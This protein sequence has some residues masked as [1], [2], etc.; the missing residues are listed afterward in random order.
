MFGILRFVTNTMGNITIYDIEFIQTIRQCRHHT[1][2][3]IVTQPPLW[4][5]WIAQ[6]SRH[7]VRLE[8]DSKLN[9][10]SESDFD[11]NSLR[12]LDTGLDS[13]LTTT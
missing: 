1:I 6:I 2:K 11:S 10:D 12:S 13:N 8:F 5:L 3:T 7:Q 9:F 4:W